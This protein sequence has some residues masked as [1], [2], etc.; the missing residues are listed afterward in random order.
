MRRVK[1]ILCAALLLAASTARADEAPATLTLI[2]EGGPAAILEPASD[3]TPIA[4]PACRGLMWEILDAERGLYAPLGRAP[5]PASQ[6]ANVVGP[7]GIRTEPPP[8][9]YYPAAVRAIALVGVRCQPERPLSVADCAE[10]VTVTSSPVTV[11][12]P[13]P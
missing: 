13:A 2:K 7:E 10:V 5:C 1:P 6:P 4:V 11:Q 12:S 3:D 9:P 8:L